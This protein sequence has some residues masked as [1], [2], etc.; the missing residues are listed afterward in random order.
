MSDTPEFSRRFTLAEIGTVPKA[1]TVTADSAECLALS[2][3]FGL[4]SL[5]RLS[6]SAELAATE[7]GIEARGLLSA[8]LVQTCVATGQ[9]LASSL[10]E[11][12][13]IRFEAPHSDA[14]EDELELS[15]DDCDVV[16]HDGQAIDLGE[17]A[18]Q[19]LAL[20]IDPFPRAANA[21]EILK[22]AGILGEADASPFAQLKGMFAKK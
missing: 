21:D 6:A 14:T 7:R 1:V 5:D 12:F 22:A 15:E 19:T 20:S 2:R 4:H 11:A 17:A 16:E 10:E 18:A 13:R 8:H 3:R 9:R